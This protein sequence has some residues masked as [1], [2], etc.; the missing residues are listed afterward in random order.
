MYIVDGLAHSNASF[1]WPAAVACPA[2]AAILEEHPP[3]TQSWNRTELR[4]LQ[5]ACT[6]LAKKGV[7]A[8]K[9]PVVV[10]LAAG[11]GRATMGVGIAPTLTAS[12]AKSP[13]A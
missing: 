8:G 9:V 10:D 3:A 4:N 13:G 11:P 6:R 2:L 1:N 5:V 12:H 7:D